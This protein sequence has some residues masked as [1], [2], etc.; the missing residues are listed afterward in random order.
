[1][2]DLR[3]R[4]ERWIETG[5]DRPVNDSGQPT[6]APDIPS[7]SVTCSQA[8]AIASF[9]AAQAG[10]QVA[11]SEASWLRLAVLA[12]TAPAV[13]SLVVMCALEEGFIATLVEPDEREADLHARVLARSVV[14]RTVVDDA[15]VAEAS[16]SLA[17][18]SSARAPATLA[19]APTAAASATGSV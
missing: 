4:I 14:A 12:Q 1:M 13:Q 10:H 15:D 2:S 7:A 9:L 11:S 5:S 18:Q 17:G 19:A 3:A 6:G 16:D 8:Q